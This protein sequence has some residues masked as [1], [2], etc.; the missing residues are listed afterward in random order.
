V[1]IYNGV[2]ADAIPLSSYLRG[3][4]LEALAASCVGLGQRQLFFLTNRKRQKLGGSSMKRL[5]AL[6]VFVAFL[7]VS[8]AFAGEPTSS[9]ADW[10]KDLGWGNG[11]RDYTS[12]HD[13]AYQHHDP[14]YEG[15]I[16]VDL[17]VYK[18]DEKREGKKKLIPDVVTVENK[19]DFT[20]ENGGTYVVATYD[21]SGLWQKKDEPKEEPEDV[22]SE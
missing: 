12:G 21:L 2:V 4:P 1:N 6:L 20:N 14:D 15:G 11:L 18:A 13:H 16:G 10:N 3:K 9:Q 7:S 5:L 22:V 17:I 19:Y 8:F